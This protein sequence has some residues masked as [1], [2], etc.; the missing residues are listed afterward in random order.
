MTSLLNS[1]Y[2]S[3]FG[4]SADNYRNLHAARRRGG[5]ESRDAAA[6]FSLIYRDFPLLA[7]DRQTRDRKGFRVIIIA[8]VTNVNIRASLQPAYPDCRRIEQ[9]RARDDPDEG[10]NCLYR[11]GRT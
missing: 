7:D 5:I 6:P 1:Y 9:S 8:S 11:D 2:R 4:I 10:R 3:I